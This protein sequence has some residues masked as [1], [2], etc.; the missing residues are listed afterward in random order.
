MA[1]NLTAELIADCET[2]QGL[3]LSPS[4][5][6]VVYAIC[7]FWVRKH[8][9]EHIT[10]SLWIVEVGKANSAR[11]LTSGKY[12]DSSP[13]FSPD[14]KSITFVSDRANAGKGGAL[15]IMPLEGGGEG[16][17]L[18]DISKEKGVGDYKWSPDGKRIAF[19][20]ADEKSEEKKKRE[21]EK[22]DAKVWG[23]DWEFSRLRVLDMETQEVTTLFE[24]KAHVASFDWSPDGKGMVLTEWEN[25]EIDCLP[26]G[27][28]IKLVEMDT[29]KVSQ[30]CEVLGE[31]SS[32]IYC[33]Q[34]IYWIGQSIG[35]G[36][37]QSQSVWRMKVD[38]QGARSENVA[39]GKSNC[40]A[41]LKRVGDKAVVYV[42][43]GLR[44]KLEILDEE[45]IY[46]GKS[47]PNS[48]RSAVKMLRH[49]SAHGSPCGSP[50]YTDHCSDKTLEEIDI[51][52]AWD[53]VFD[54]GNVTVA[55]VKALDTAMPQEVFSIVDGKQCQLSTH[56]KQLA[57]LKLA[58][59]SI[60]YCKAQ[61]G[62]P[63][64]GILSV[65][66]ALSGKEKP[67]ATV[68]VIHGGPYSRVNRGTEFLLNFCEW[69][70]SLGYVVIQPNY[71]G[72]SGH[73]QKFASAV[74]GNVSASYPD[75]IDLL[76]KAIADG[77]VDK[78][79]VA[80]AG[81]SQGG[82]L[83]YF[84]PTQDS[85]FHF[86]AAIAGAGVSDWDTM[87]FTSD[88]PTYEARLSGNAPWM[89]TTNQTNG[90]KSSPIY[91]MQNIRTP[92]L[93]L[94]GEQD[95]RVPVEQAIGFH[96]GLRARGKECEMVI[97]PRE[98]HC[99]PVPFERPHYIHMLNTMKAFLEKH[100]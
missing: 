91:H 20:S 5:S 19:T 9:Q 93:I 87:A 7:P 98:G 62:T 69:F 31:S 47:S 83:S 33:R 60:L 2:P 16:L 15:Y 86:A 89:N 24:E 1:S 48:C 46:E 85:T 64:D 88:I 14:G 39:Y 84:A 78:D 37:Q 75:C 12:N 100:L 34:W 40:A 56:G 96:R 11:Q 18:T 50:S 8:K 74:L 76:Q 95:Q 51:S 54:N 32:L 59:T 57:N 73:G 23:E 99:W 55:V 29:K 66:S 6:H 53:V 10:A 90:R 67:H 97:Y 45:S 3:R 42:Q 27:G 81:W 28:K 4:G 49:V 71:R 17:P 26:Q 82:Y 25:P 72:G 21:E 30:L 13:Q 70:L 44:D 41:G 79:R 61:D 36:S 80:I 65:P 38:K 92:F 58:N 77:V 43:D 35:E 22:D 68:L 52:R 94:H 63:L